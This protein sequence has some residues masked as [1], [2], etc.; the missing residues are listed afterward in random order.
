MCGITGIYNFKQAQNRERLL[1]TINCMANTLRH[2]GPD[3]GGT[4]IDDQSKLALGHRRLA[5]RDLSTT[6]HQPMMSSCGRF[7]IVYNGEVYSHLEIGKEL[8]K[9]GRQ[10][11]GSS[12]TEVILEAC[13]EWG[14]ERTLKNL[15]GMF[16][17]ALFDRETRDL[18]LARDR[19]GIKPLYWGEM[20][21]FLI[22]GSELKALRK[23][24]EWNPELD[25][26]ALS[27]T[28]TYQRLI[29]YIKKYIN[30]NQG[31]F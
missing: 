17:F 5:I 13:A 6:G 22:F 26:N 19:L 7:V 12:D 11:K 21:G 29:L 18:Y 3:S 20:N 28:I 16:A 14:V 10:L 9:C 31:I 15:I 1:A 25:R 8:E 27:V 4:W 30:W 24:E 23:A 2:R